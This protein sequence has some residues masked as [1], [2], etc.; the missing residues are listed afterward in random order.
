LSADSIDIL[1]E[2]L[3]ALS[4][5]VVPDTEVLRLLNEVA[6]AGGGITLELDDGRWK[7]I[8]REGRFVLKKD[9]VRARPSTMPPRPTVRPPR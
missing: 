1:R 4:G 7:L 9:D 8:R 6:A 2:R 5:Q 3:H